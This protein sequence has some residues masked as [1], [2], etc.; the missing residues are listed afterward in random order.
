M[1]KI[2]EEFEARRDKEMISR[3]RW[4]DD[5]Q[6][7]KLKEDDAFNNGGKYWKSEHLTIA[8][9][10]FCDGYEAAKASQWI[11][12]KH[13]LPSTIH[14]IEEFDKAGDKCTF[15]GMVSDSLE[16]SDG[17]GLARGHYRDDGTWCIYDAEHD[18][19]LVDKTE[20][21]H[22]MPILKGPTE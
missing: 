22:W 4:C 13:D 8:L 11:S 21:T 10:A 15:H 5:E 16:V 3:F 20:V 19:Q 1:D 9:F 18:F 6:S 7:Y 12:V 2:R 17:H 14:E